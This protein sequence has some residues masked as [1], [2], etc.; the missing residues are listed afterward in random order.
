[1]LKQKKESA[2]KDNKEDEKN[3]RNGGGIFASRDFRH[4][5]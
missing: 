3:A 2:K 4:E 1:M 5:M